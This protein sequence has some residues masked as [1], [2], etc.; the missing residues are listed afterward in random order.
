[1]NNL[2]SGMARSHVVPGEAGARENSGDILLGDSGDH[3]SIVGVGE[4]KF[5]DHSGCFGPWH[6]DVRVY[7]SS[8]VCPMYSFCQICEECLEA[9]R[10]DLLSVLGLRGGWN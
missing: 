3:A 9:L 8:S 5:L 10:I 4:A 1:M 2:H 7:R 6:G